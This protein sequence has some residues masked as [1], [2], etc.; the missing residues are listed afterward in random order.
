MKRVIDKLKKQYYDI[1][2][3][4]NF[5]IGTKSLNY[6]NIEYY[7]TSLAEYRKAIKILEQ[8]LERIE[9]YGRED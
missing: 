5:E 3:T 1:K 6:Q 9:E 4:Y 8:E 7:N 2:D